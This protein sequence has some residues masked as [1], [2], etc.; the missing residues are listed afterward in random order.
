[1]AL[2][3]VGPALLK[4][5]ATVFVFGLLLALPA[6]LVLLPAIRLTRRPRAAA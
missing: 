1:V 5:L 3:A 6:S 4:P 2:I